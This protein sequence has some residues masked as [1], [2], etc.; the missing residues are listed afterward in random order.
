MDDGLDEARLQI[1]YEAM[2]AAHRGDADAAAAAGLRIGTDISVDGQAGM[3]VW[4]LLRYQ[5]AEMLGHTPSA[6]DLHQIAG[7]CYPAFSI[8]VRGD[9]RLLENT[10]RTAFALATAQEH[11]TGGKLVLFGALA[12]GVLMDNPETELAAIR[13]HLAAWWQRNI[14]HFRAQGAFEDRSQACRKGS[15]MTT[16]E[17]G[18]D[19]PSS[20]QSITARGLDDVR[21]E[22]LREAI[23]SAHRGDA[24]G[25]LSASH[26]L[27][28]GNPAD[29]QPTACIWWL[30]R[31]RLY[32]LLGRQPTRGDITQIAEYAEQRRFG[33][34][35]NDASLLQDVMLTA[36]KLAPLDQEVKGDK[37]MTAGVAALG[38]LL[39]EPSADLE[40]VRP[41]LTAWW[42][43]NQDIYRPKTVPANRFLKRRFRT[44][45]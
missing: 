4:Y 33:E 2:A 42:L 15:V 26:S 16:K 40:A 32:Q 1:L 9:S 17:H 24:V 7:R 20:A 19:S 12:V 31:H 35:V 36:W 45:H 30:L 34:I 14:E 18:R 43:E 23:L 13:P 39:R 21:W 41:E 5:V 25:A 37:F 10:L 22:I 38:V 44:S 27:A 29:G 11:V 28:H 8:V 6:D 3:Y